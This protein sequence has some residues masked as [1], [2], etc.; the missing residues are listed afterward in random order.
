MSRFIEAALLMVGRFGFR[1][2]R[3]HFAFSF[4]LLGG[5]VADEI[6]KKFQWRW[7]SRVGEGT[8]TGA[9]VQEGPAAGRAI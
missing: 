2:V 1:C 5:G 3:F 7:P 8:P 6:K 9:K 4:S